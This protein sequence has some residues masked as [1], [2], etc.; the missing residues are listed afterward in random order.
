MNKYNPYRY[1]VAKQRRAIKGSDLAKKTGLNPNTISRLKT[2]TDPD[3]ETVELIAKALRYPKEFFYMPNIEILSEHAV[4]F[5]SLSKMTALNRDAAIAAGSLGMLFWEWVDKRFD[6]PKSDVPDLRHCDAEEAAM[7]LRQHWKVGEKP[8]SD[9]VKLIESKGVRVLSLCIDTKQI[10]AYSFFK[11]ETPYVFLNNFK[12]AEHSVFDTA[13]ELGHLVLHQHSELTRSKQ[14]EAQANEFAAAFLMPR[15]DLCAKAPRRITSNSLIKM[16]KRWK[17]SA[18]ALAHRLKQIGRVSD[19]QYRSLCIDLSKRGYR[20]SEPD[21]I[22]RQ[23][24]VV[25]QQV[26]E[27][28]WKERVTKKQIASDLNVPL[29][30]LENLLF[31]LTREN[32]RPDINEAKRLEVITSNSE[33]FA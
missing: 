33:S 1:I 15:A 19:W 21:G 27:A 6:L 13:H 22:Q 18:M 24:S 5:R 12:T 30:E 29:D 16:K 10:D 7:A 25:V 11:N 28:L 3:E 17:V 20:T 32:V 31:K 23:K 14:V 8:I 26:L 4:S 2:D 9:I